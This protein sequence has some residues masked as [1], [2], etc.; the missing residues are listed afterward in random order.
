MASGFELR[1]QT[2]EGVGTSFAGQTAK[3]YN[4]STV[5]YN[6]AGMTLLQG[7]QAAAS[8][9]EIVPEISFRGQATGA[10]LVP[11]VP[12]GASGNITPAAPVPASFAMWDFQSNLKFGIAV[13]SPFGERTNYQDGWVGRYHALRTELTNINVTPTAAYRFNEHFSVGVGVQ[14][15][16]FNAV[17]SNAINLRG[18]GLGLVDAKQTLAGNGLGVGGDIGFLYEFDPATRIGLNYRSRIHYNLTGGTSIQAP[19][20][21]TVASP[22]FRNSG[23]SVGLTT[24]D[25]VNLGFYH[26]VSTQIAVMADVQYTT[27]SVLKQLNVNYDNGRAATIIGEHWRDTWFGSIGASYA[28]NPQTKFL[29]GVGYDEAP[30]TDQNRTARLPDANRLLVSGGVSY[31]LNPY[32]KANLAYSHIFTNG[33]IVNEASSAASGLLQ[34]FY[35]FSANLVSASVELRF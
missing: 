12:G 17:L 21:L 19:G 22:A 11:L 2:S 8:I 25:F 35:T 1:E 28:W 23:A 13:T 30:M 31:E 16:F 9:T 26:D 29:V 6:P 15:A 20:Y 3:A 7:N 24:P 33:A 32:L 10:G 14:A 27:W 4:L 5:Y 34:G 18:L